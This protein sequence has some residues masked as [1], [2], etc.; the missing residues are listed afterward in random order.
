VTANVPTPGQPHRHRVKGFSMKLIL[1]AIILLV[2]F[3]VLA[4]CQREEPAHSSEGSRP[5]SD[6]EAILAKGGSFW[7]STAKVT[8]KTGDKERELSAGDRYFVW[9]AEPVAPAAKGGYVRLRLHWKLRGDKAAKGVFAWMSTEGELKDSES[10][11]SMTAWDPS[12]ALEGNEGDIEVD[13]NLQKVRAHGDVN[14]L[15][16]LTE[17]FDAKILGNILRVKVAFP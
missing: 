4:G 14:M 17:G 9:P 7:S 6:P 8:V 12:V 16:Y 2:S 10:T 1:Q 11:Y 5:P 3:M 13:F 15:I